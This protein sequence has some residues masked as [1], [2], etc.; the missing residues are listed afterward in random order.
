MALTISASSASTDTPTAAAFLGSPPAA[1]GFGL[2]VTAREVAAP[3]PVAALGEAG[4]EVTS[5]A[6]VLGSDWIVYIPGAPEIVNAKLPA[7]AAIAPF[8]VY[9]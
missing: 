7:L 2:L 4:C 9:C 6:I 5:V 1:G 3:E 8:R